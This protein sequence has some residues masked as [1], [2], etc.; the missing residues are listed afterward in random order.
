VGRSRQQLIDARAC[1]HIQAE[2]SLRVLGVALGHLAND[3]VDLARR[4]GEI[5]ARLWPQEQ[6]H[7]E[8]F[9]VLRLE[10]WCDVFEGAGLRAWDRFAEARRHAGE[11]LLLSSRYWSF[12]WFDLAAATALNAASS[13]A[14]GPARATFLAEAES[15]MAELEGMEP[16]YVGSQLTLYQ[17]ARSHLLGDVSA[18]LDGLRVLCNVPHPILAACAQAKLG[19]LLRGPEGAAL[20]SLG[21]TALRRW[22]K[23]PEHWVA[24]ILP[25]FGAPP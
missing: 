21:V 10:I 4:Q 11:S 20:H 16:K 7:G 18:T 13:S 6:L 23:S 2:A 15:A 17:T 14:P 9:K 5:S 3:E 25:G 8:R 22:V 24:F 19:A 1:G 12:W